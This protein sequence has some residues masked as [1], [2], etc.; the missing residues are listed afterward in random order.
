MKGT[1]MKKVISIAVLVT[2]VFAAFSMGKNSPKGGST[3]KGEGFKIDV[4]TFDVKVKQ[5][6]TKTVTIKVQREE[7]FKRDVKLQIGAVQGISIE[8]NDVL[9]KASDKAEV[10]LTIMVPRDAAIGKYMVSIT[11]TPVS[12]EATSA[13]FKVKVVA[14]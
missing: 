6:E 3:V 5:G 11:A 9:V 1:K 4:P 14:P 2:L 13:E 10:Q 7:S 8:P 12:G